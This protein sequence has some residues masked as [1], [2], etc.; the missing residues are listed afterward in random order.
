MKDLYPERVLGGCGTAPS[1]LGL[2]RG[3]RVSPRFPP[4]DTLSY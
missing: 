4:E 2:L 1:N 3:A